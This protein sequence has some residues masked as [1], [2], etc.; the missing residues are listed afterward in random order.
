MVAATGDGGARG[1]MV[2]M[3]TRGFKGYELGCMVDR[4]RCHMPP[5]TNTNN[6]TLSMPH[7]AI[8]INSILPWFRRYWDS[9][10]V[11]VL[12]LDVLSFVDIVSHACT[13]FFMHKN[14]GPG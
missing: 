1:V 10:H 6:N 14:V 7:T 3:R 11:L 12:I 2:Q 8:T 5:N 9:V 13:G 4:Q